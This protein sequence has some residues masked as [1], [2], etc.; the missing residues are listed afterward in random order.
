MTGMTE[1]L[2]L[3]DSYLKECEA[4][5]KKVVEEKKIV[6]DKTVFY[7]QGGGQPFDVG[8]MAIGS[9]IFSVVGVRREAGEAVHEVDKPGLK[10]GDEVKC[11]IDWQRRYKLMRMH[12]AAHV[13]AATL[14]KET[15]ALITG[16]QLGTEESRFD[17][18]LEQFD[19]SVFDE[20][21]VKANTLLFQNLELK[22]YE[23]P[24]EE[25]EK[26]P[27]IIKLA[28]GLPPSIAVLRIVEIPG[29]DLQADGG[30]HVKNLNEV[31]QINI[32][33]LENKGK[34]NRR[35]YFVLD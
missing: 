26:L 35:V 4:T 1:L 32:T 30:T 17:F 29:I 28:K 3:K 18:S 25:A 16:N 27:N 11:E 12:T 2:Y 22:V 9:E 14:F 20:T 19:R 8:T 33:K 10:Q 31:G 24:R 6:L 21:V 34:A 13:I 15:S 7:P 23:L 5:V